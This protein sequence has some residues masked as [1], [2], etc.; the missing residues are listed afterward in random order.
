[1]FLALAEAVGTFWTGT[2]TVLGP[3]GLTV[4][5]FFGPLLFILDVA[6]VWDVGIGGLRGSG[7]DLER[8]REVAELIWQTVSSSGTVLELIWV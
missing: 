7:T 5:V 3:A 1:M 6:A 4:T 2:A 8:V